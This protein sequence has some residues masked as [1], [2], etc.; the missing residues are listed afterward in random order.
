MLVVYA[1]SALSRVGAEVS[2]TGVYQMQARQNAQLGLS[3][4]IGDLQ[5]FAGEDDMLTGMAGVTGIPAGAGQ[6]QRNWGVVWD[7]NGQF[8]RWLVPGA[9]TA[10]LPLVDGSDALTLVAAG[11]LG[12]D[13][14]DREHVRVRLVPVV[15]ST[16]ERSAVPLGRYAWWVGDEGVKLSA[17]GADPAHAI[18]ELIDLSPL[19]AELAA[20]NILSHAQLALVPTSV[21]STALAGQLRANFH[22][23]GLTHFGIT[24]L[25]SFP[26]YLNINTTN[27]RFWRGVAATYNRHKQGGAPT[28]SPG[29]FADALVARFP[30]ADPGAGKRA[31]GPYPS[32]DLFLNSAALGDALAA[33]GGT[34]QA[35][36]DVMRPMLAVRSDTFRVRAYGDAANPADPSRVEA[37]AWVE[38]IVQRVKVT[39]A[40]AE[41]RFIITHFR[42][43]GP[44]DI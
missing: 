32:V 14:A 22:A 36:G 3:Q 11:S 35:F 20:G 10:V 41:G 19:V 43:L 5:R 28:L 21:T 2:A 38:A 17:Q 15:V 27:H 37:T 34:L 23:L 1:L 4:A 26:G 42:W 40:S 18:D 6:A 13:G 33:G 29:M 39:P 24:P 12:A 16:R 30:V 9:D 7:G 8:F 31:G 44:D 25:G